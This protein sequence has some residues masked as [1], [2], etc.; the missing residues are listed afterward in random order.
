MQRCGLSKRLLSMEEKCTQWP[1]CFTSDSP[2]LQLKTDLKR[3]I[4]WS[5]TD[6]NK[7]QNNEESNKIF[8]QKLRE[9][10]LENTS[11]S[12][13]NKQILKAGRETATTL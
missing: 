9:N 3:T 7:I 13:F 4:G 8:N 6:W 10:I 5:V 11:Y 1:L 12:D 2:S